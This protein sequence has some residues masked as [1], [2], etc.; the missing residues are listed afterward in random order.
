MKIF[1]G[2]TDVR[3]VDGVL[4]LGFGPA[5]VATIVV[6]VVLGMPGV[7]IVV[8]TVSL[9]AGDLELDAW[10]IFTAINWFSVGDRQPLTKKK[11]HESLCLPRHAIYLIQ[12]PRAFH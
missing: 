8:K 6:L 2:R 5:L 9:L 11:A 4:D 7:G 10:F 12:A 1:G 3:S